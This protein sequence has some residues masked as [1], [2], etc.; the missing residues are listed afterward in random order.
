MH[1]ATTQKGDLNT[2]TTIRHVTKPH[3]NLFLELG[4]HAK[5]AARLQAISHQYI[6]DAQSLQATTMSELFPVN[7]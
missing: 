6:S 4:F 7:L 5:E 1:R 3:A 2:A